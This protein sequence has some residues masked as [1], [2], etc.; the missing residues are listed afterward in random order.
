MTRFFALLCVLGL[1]LLIHVQVLFPVVFQVEAEYFHF[2]KDEFL[3]SFAQEREAG[4]AT[5]G[6][7]ESEVD[8]YRK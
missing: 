6:A 5:R 7:G 4:A 2:V 1:L 3:F 8:G